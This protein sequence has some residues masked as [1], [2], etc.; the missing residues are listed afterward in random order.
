[1]PELVATPAAVR[2]VSAEP[3]L[4]PVQIAGKNIG[5]TLWIGGQRGCDGTH[6]GI[7]T[8]DCPN[9]RHHHHDHRCKRGLDWVIV[10]GESGANARPCCTGWVRSIVQQCQAAGVP[11]FVKQLGSNPKPFKADTTKSEARAWTMRLKNRKGGDP[12][13]W[14]EDLRVRE[15]PIL[16]R[17][18]ITELCGTPDPDVR[19]AVCGRGSNTRRVANAMGLA[20]HL[21]DAP[22]GEDETIKGGGGR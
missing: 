22:V 10:G 16:A 14:A 11:V 6:E 7:G 5:G 15:M 17:K 12:A 19:A 3:L 8:P 21:P 2:F 13:E 20:G 9:G 1:M 18:L 4:G